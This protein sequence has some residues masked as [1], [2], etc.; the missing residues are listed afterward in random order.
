MSLIF[1]SETWNMKYLKM[2]KF[3]Y[4]FQRISRDISTF[5]CLFLFSVFT[6][7]AFVLYLFLL[8]VTIQ[9]SFFPYQQTEN[10]SFLKPGAQ[11]STVQFLGWLIHQQWTQLD[12]FIAISNTKMNKLIN[13]SHLAHANFFK[14]DSQKQNRQ[15]KGHFT[16]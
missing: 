11:Y 8:I 10:I 14:I 2:R 4:F 16:L 9:R 1:K 5:K 3:K 6:H 12:S 7:N 13:M 15:I